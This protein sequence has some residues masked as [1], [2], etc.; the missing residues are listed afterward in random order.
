MFS[1]G[2]F[3]TK[4]F[5]FCYFLVVRLHHDDLVTTFELSR[6]LTNTRKQHILTSYLK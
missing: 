3:I 2:L 1:L 5:S 6:I 4:R